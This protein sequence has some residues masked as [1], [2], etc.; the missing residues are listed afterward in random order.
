[1]AAGGESH[2]GTATLSAAR[3]SPSPSEGGMPAKVASLLPLRW[4]FRGL[5]WPPEDPGLGGHCCASPCAELLF[6]AFLPRWLAHVTDCPT[7]EGLSHLSLCPSPGLIS[8]C[9]TLCAGARMS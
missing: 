1:M 4:H 6:S 7:W 2:E 5:S 9:A 8:S 3:G